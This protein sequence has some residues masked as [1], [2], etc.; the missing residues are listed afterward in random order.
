[1]AHA[2]LLFAVHLCAVDTRFNKCNLLTD[3]KTP[4]AGSML[5]F[6]RD[7]S[8]KIG[9]SVVYRIYGMPFVVVF[10]TVE[11]EVLYQLRT[12][13]GTATI[14]WL[15]MTVQIMVTAMTV[16]GRLPT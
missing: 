15:T 13:S 3:I 6:C 5:T 11:A 10:Q 14:T 16:R 8:D 12:L 9:A 4:A 1:M 2:L 7:C